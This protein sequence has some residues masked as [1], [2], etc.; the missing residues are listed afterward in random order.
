MSG[1]R[2][3]R[4]RRLLRLPALICARQ[5]I[6]LDEL[7]RLAEYRDV[8]ALKRDLDQLMMFGAPP[9]SPADFVTVSIEEER[10]FLDFPM[11]LDRP[12]ALNAHEWAA[13]QRRLIRELEFRTSGDPVAEQLRSLLAQLD[14]APVSIEPADIYAGK[15]NLIAEALHEGL[16]LEFRYRALSSREPEL[17]QVDPWAL[18]QHGAADYLIGW[19]HSRKDGRSFH[20]DRMDDLYILEAPVE[21]SAPADLARMARESLI[22]RPGPGISARIGFRS[23][24]R[25]ALEAELPLR[26]IR[27]MQPEE[28]GLAD[29]EPS[30][31]GG[32]EERGDEKRSDDGRADRWL[33]A[34]TSCPEGFWFRS[35]IRGFGESVVI[36]S[37]EHLRRE[38]GEELAQIP[39][40][41]LIE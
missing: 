11:G 3:P 9:F 10:V 13:V 2:E 27:E 34:A 23:S 1:G 8:D 17:R 39:L 40:P 30:A 14:P 7:A 21:T 5:G 38:F 24:V 32:D 33:S 25:S 16:Q 22:F 12:L 26:D 4:L 41:E 36:L 18:L 31:A 37:P 20:L 35:L 6:T 28:R 29:I 19:C 15:R